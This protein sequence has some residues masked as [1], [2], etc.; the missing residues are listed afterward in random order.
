MKLFLALAVLALTACSSKPQVPYV[1]PDAPAGRLKSIA[2]LPYYGQPVEPSVQST[3]SRLWTEWWNDVYPGVQWALPGEVSAQLL[4]ANVFD[5]WAANEKS[6]VQSGQYSPDVLSQICATTKS[7]GIMQATVYGAQPGG[8][9]RWWFL[10]PIW[11]SDGAPGTARMTLTVFS[12]ASRTSIWSAH[13]D[14]KYSGDYTASKMIE[15][16]LSTMASKISP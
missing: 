16:A 11:A 7:E 14:I 1:A 3:Q 10:K 4:A 5:A 13:A 6:F 2:F 8:G 9:S 15:Y 12:C